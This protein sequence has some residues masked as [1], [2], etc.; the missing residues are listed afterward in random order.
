MNFSAYEEL[1]TFAKNAKIFIPAWN[2][3]FR[4]FSYIECPKMY[5]HTDLS[6]YT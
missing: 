4:E 3:Y 2:V 1:C 6:E 5:T